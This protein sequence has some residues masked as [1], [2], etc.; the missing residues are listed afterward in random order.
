MLRRW[1]FVLFF[2]AVALAAAC[3]GN[4]DSHGGIQK[5]ESANLFLNP[6]F[7]QGEKPWFSLTTEGWGTPFRVSE[8]AAR[9]GGHSAFLELGGRPEAGTKVF[10]VVQDVQPEEFPELI[11]GYYQVGQWIRG[12]DI[13]YLQF[14][15]I[16]IGAKNMPGGFTNH[17]I[18]YLLAGIDRPPLEIS[19][20]KFIFV[21]TEEPAPGDWV[22]FERNIQQDFIEQWG[23]APEGLDRIRVLFEVRYDDKEAGVTGPTAD[24][25]Y[26]D[27]H[28]EPAGANT[29]AA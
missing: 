3:G 14:V 27:L 7:E 20:A 11:S 5:P 29:N 13:Q 16:A 1:R 26:D 4:S 8:D 22:H 6:S 12:T 28:L 24:V 15:V 25:F 18:R 10:G 2:A 17:Q 21:A 19:N 23:A 9:S